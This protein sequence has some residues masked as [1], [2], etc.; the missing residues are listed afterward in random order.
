MSSTRERKD[1]N[2]D[3][4]GVFACCNTCALRLNEYIEK[5]FCAVGYIVGQWPY[6][7][8]GLVLVFLGLCCFGFVFTEI[9][10]NIFD[11]WTPTDSPVFEEGEFIDFYWS[12]KD[13]GLLVVSGYAK[14]G[15]D[16]NI[17][18]EDYLSQWYQIHLDLATNLPKKNFTFTGT[19]NSEQH[20]TFGYFAGIMSYH[21]RIIASPSKSQSKLHRKL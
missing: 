13:Y 11:L 16:T 4:G 17:L 10:T 14:D 2:T 9:E 3:D 8:L 18:S 21:I 6:I 1:N 19:D 20:V 12:D 5:A 7:V 15:E